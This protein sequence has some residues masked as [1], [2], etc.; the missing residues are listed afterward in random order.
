M[1]K[2]LNTFAFTYHSKL[3][4]KTYQGSITMRIPGMLERLSISTRKSQILG[5]MY[6]VRDEKTNEPT[7][8]GVDDNTE[9]T[10]HVQAW[11]EHCIVQPPD[12]LKFGGDD[13]PMDEG[14]FFTLF[15]EASTYETKFR[16]RGRTADST[17]GGSASGGQAD[18]AAQPAQANGG[19]AP[20]EVVGREV[21]ASL[22]A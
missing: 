1:I 19:S 5:G 21:Q 8:R 4:E 13:A 22:D 18:G 6:C 14:V 2:R 3:E 17:V 10:A 9:Y 20:T 12:W 11:L 16:D 15:K 7:G